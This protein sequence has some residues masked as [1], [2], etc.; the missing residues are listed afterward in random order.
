MASGH[1][2]TSDGLVLT[3]ANAS[4][5]IGL[6]GA[7][8]TAAF[9]VFSTGGNSFVELQPACFA[10]GTRIATDRGEIAVEALAVGDQVRALLDNALAP[11]IWIGRRTIDC[12]HHP[13]PSRV[14]PVRIRAGAFGPGGR[15]VTCSCHRTTPSMSTKC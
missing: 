3:G 9:D 7:F 13:K 10:A 14:W 6:Q 11:I 15:A 4:Q 8:T 2:F 12:A 1:S 5:T